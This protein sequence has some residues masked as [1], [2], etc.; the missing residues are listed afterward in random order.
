MKLSIII[1]VYN[2][3]R[4]FL[5]LL[6]KVKGVELGNVKKEIIVVEDCSTD[7]TREM[8]KK[9][10]GKGIKI[11]FHERN[12]GKGAAV[13]TGFKYA[14]GD[15]I[16]I[17]DSDLEY[18]PKEYPK[19]LKPI[20]RNETKVVYGNRIHKGHKPRYY[21]YYLG[22][23]GLSLLTTLIYGTKIHDM[24]TG[25]KVF[26]KEVTEGMKLRSTRF[27]FDPEITCKILK[28]H[29]KI[30][31]VPIEYKS[32]AIEEGKKITWKDGILAAWVLVKYRFVD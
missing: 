4:Y 29:Y 21:F 12:Q 22:N 24:E 27:D 23:I 2:E 9:L 31:D 14:T 10:R 16:L 3:K 15:I 25:Y 17:Q 8:L 20:L 19:L 26:R 28:R 32:R 7:G 13:R 30:K 1:P 11:I 18:D 6:K 5:A